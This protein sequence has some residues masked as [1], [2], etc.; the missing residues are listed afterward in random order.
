MNKNY[1]VFD[2]ETI[3]DIEAIERSEC[4]K[5]GLKDYSD[6]IKYKEKQL[7]PGEKSVFVKLPFH[8][9]VEISV[10]FIN[11]EKGLFK[12]TSLPNQSEEILINSFW[13]IF[14]KSRNPVLVTF[15]G[16]NFDL[17]V[18]TMRS[19]KYQDIFSDI[20]RIGICQY[21][22]TNDKW[23]NNGPNY[24]N[25]YSKYHVD[26]MEFSWGSRYSLSDV[27]GMLNIPVKTIS[28][29]NNINDLYYTGQTEIIQN[30]C[31]EDVLATSELFLYWKRLTDVN[32]F[33]FDKI[34]DFI[35]VNRKSLNKTS[36]K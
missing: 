31:I 33:N 27:C 28:G 14:M 17:P 23:E 32:L 16:R 35:H 13:E 19:M 34:K 20:A 15:N 3:H 2:I 5:L 9:P 6:Y 21:F 4:P 22:D 7:K 8:I 1:L 11:F 26:L 36:P 29:G 30:Y 10:S 18:I 12:I 25:R 24:T